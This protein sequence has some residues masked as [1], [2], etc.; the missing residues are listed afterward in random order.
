MIYYKKKISFSGLN[1]ELI[2]ISKKIE[3]LKLPKGFLEFIN[4][5]LF[6]LFANIKEHSRAKSAVIEININKK[7]C[8][9]KIIDNGIGLRK[10]YLLKKIYP[11]DDFAAIE[12]ALSGLSTKN[13]QER[14]FGLYSIRKLTNA[15]KGEMIIKSGFTQAAIK[16]SQINFK[17][18][19]QKI[20]G[21]DI[22]IRTPVKLLDFYKAVE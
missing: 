21:V 6:E 12:F 15:L 22:I 1:R 11:K 16:E 19:A 10:S 7:N 18:T 2:D 14:G 9:V 8:L 17:K 4:Y 13:L 20:Q 5:T 3:G